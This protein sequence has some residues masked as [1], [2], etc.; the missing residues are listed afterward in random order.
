MTAAAWFGP[1]GLGFTGRVQDPA[2][3]IISQFSLPGLS[4]DGPWAGRVPGGLPTKRHDQQ[5]RRIGLAQ[6]G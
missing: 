4:Y 3:D 1:A 6:L 5:R 2:A